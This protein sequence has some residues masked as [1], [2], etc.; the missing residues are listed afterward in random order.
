[1][2]PRRAGSQIGPISHEDVLDRRVA[3]FGHTRFFQ[4]AEDAIVPLFL[5]FVAFL[6]SALS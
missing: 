1:M 2:F 4:F 3:D 5:G 6:A